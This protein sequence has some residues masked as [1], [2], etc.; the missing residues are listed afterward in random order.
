MGSRASQRS[1]LLGWDV[2]PSDSLESVGELPIDSRESVGSLHPSNNDHWV[3]HII[4]AIL[5][6]TEVY[7]WALQREKSE[8]SAEELAESGGFVSLGALLLVAL[9]EC[10]PDD[11]HLRR[12]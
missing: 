8:T 7:R 4:A 10:I 9:M 11:T 1:L 3:D 6:C 2:D 12:Q 5:S